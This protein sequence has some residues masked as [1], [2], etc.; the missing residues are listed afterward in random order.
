MSATG[1]PT[2]IAAGLPPSDGLGLPLAYCP[3]CGGVMASRDPACP[4]CGYDFLPANLTR[5]RNAAFSQAGDIVLIIAAAV[6]GLGCVLLLIGS[7]MAIA[8]GQ[9]GPAVA[10]LMFAVVMLAHVIVFM[11]VQRLEQPP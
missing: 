1:R 4:H 7:I 5:S 11:R 3:K 8:E 10:I 2:D 6:A 9:L